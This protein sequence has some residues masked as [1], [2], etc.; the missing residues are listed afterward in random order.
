MS[1]VGRIDRVDDAAHASPPPLLSIQ[2]TL[3]RLVFLRSFATCHPN[4]AE[5]FLPPTGPPPPQVPEGFNAA[6]SDQYQ[7]W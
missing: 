5:Q 4:M 3:R 2:G 7:A 6:W 1:R